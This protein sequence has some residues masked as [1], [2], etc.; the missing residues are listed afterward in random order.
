MTADFDD[1]ARRQS[2]EMRR[3]GLIAALAYANFVAGLA[4]FFIEKEDHELRFHG[5]QSAFITALKI[6]LGV[7]GYVG[8]FEFFF[9]QMPHFPPS[10]NQPELPMLA[11]LF[12]G[13]ALLYLAFLALFLVRI[14]F[15]IMSYQLRHVR[16][17][18]L[19]RLAQRIA[20][21]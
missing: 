20:R 11:A 18:L 1:H 8:T 10:G 13:W 15:A 5:L 4:V 6:L 19:G 9:L 12:V 2:D 3:R 21:G 17:P 14:I 16:L 7:I